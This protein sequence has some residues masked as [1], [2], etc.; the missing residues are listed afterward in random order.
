MKIILSKD[1]VMEL[2]CEK[3]VSNFHEKY[4]RNT[5][6]GRIKPEENDEIYWEGNPEKKEE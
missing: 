4:Y 2:I 5:A 6:Y 3:F 1:D